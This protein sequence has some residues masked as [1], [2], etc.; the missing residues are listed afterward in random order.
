MSRTNNLLEKLVREYTDGSKRARNAAANA[1][2][3][4]IEDIC[5]LLQPRITFDPT[6][7]RAMAESIANHGLIQ[8]ITVAYYREKSD[9]EKHATL[10]EQ[11][12]GRPVDRTG[13]R[14]SADGGYYILIAG[15]R[16]VLAM[17]SLWNRGCDVC[18]EEGRQKVPG[19]CY[20]F[21]N[22]RDA[23][24]AMIRAQVIEDGNQVSALMMQ[25]VENIHERVPPHEEACAY[26]DMYR[27]LCSIFSKLTQKVFASY[28]GRSPSTIAHALRFAELPQAVHALVAKG[29]IPYLIGVEL[30]QLA[31]LTHPQ[32]GKRVYSEERLAGVA[33][34]VLN[35]RF[36]LPEARV[37]VR[38]LIKEERQP[39]LFTSSEPS[40]DQLHYAAR[41]AELKQ[42]VRGLWQ[43]REC[44]RKAREFDQLRDPAWNRTRLLKEVHRQ[45]ETLRLC[46]AAPFDLANTHDQDEIA[47]LRRQ[48]SETLTGILQDST[49]HLTD[50]DRAGL[51]LSIAQLKHLK[52]GPP[53]PVT[54]A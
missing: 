48:V 25:L 31:L 51:R 23:D 18:I 40:A 43:V 24:R 28:V 39:T 14:E 45:L 38:N 53:S 12:R 21:H 16:R 54:P 27:F 33:H 7:I 30:A 9:A 11:V 22:E 46:L 34:L 47:F 1:R 26:A 17:L 13:L 3:I 35:K 52:A 20:R 50:E 8:P 15:N 29:L 42:A 49:N 37:L 44:L 4:S 10:I 41:H 2:H 6:T 36:R 32:T 5:I 19:D